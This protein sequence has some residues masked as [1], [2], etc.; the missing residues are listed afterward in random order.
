VKLVSHPP[1][2]PARYRARAGAGDDYGVTDPPDWRTIDWAEHLHSVEIDGR[3]VDYVDIGDQ[4]Q[5]RPIVFIHGLGGQWQNWL[6]NIPRFAQERRVIAVDLP[7][8]G[9]SEMPRERISIE[10]YGRTVA[11]LCERLELAPVVL[12]GN[13]MGG[14]VAAEV[15]IRRPDITER[16]MLVAA[17]GVSQA[18]LSARPIK[19]GAKAIALL[20]TSTLSQLRPAARRPRARHWF[21]SLVVRH[22]GAL[23][24]DLAFEGLLKGSG[25]PGFEDA[26][27]ANLSY[28]FRDRLPQIGCPTLIL[29]GEKDALIPVRDAERFRELI[30]G[31]RKVLLRD[32]GHL[33]MVERP[34][35]FNA[36]LARFLEYAVEE[37]ELEG[38][39][40]ASP[41]RDQRSSV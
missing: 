1:I 39:L 26:L 27:M 36:E 21:L 20:T 18:D 3:R 38:D 30:P 14:F 41:E 19:V 2:A 35:T 31:A 28:D 9:T 16:L 13:S 17:A 7:G 23:R 10:R 33:P 4:G 12:V 15:A 40:D 24:A 37:G 22:P 8:F 5:A 11:E 25:K 34:P 29:W 32:T 6:E